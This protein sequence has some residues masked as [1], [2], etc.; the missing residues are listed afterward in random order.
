MY[1]GNAPFSSVEADYVRSLLSKYASRVK[2]Y[3]SIQSFGSK[4]LYPFSYTT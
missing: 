2:M 1:A 4:L 3:I